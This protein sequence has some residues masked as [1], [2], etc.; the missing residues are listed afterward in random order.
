MGGEP[1]IHPFFLEMMRI[2]QEYF[3]RVTLFTNG[4]SSHLLE[5]DPREADGVNYNFN[6]GLAIKR[7]S[8][9]LDRLGARIIEVIIH[10]KTKVDVLIRNLDT[11]L[12]WSGK[13]IAVSL[14]LDCT[15]NIFAHRQQLVGTFMKVFDY[16]KTNELEVVLDHALPIC[17]VYGTGIPIST[18]GPLCNG[19]CAGMIDSD[20]SLHF[21]NQ[22]SEESLHIFSNN[23][24]VP[25]SLIENQLNLVHYKNQVNVLEK[26]CRDCPLYGRH[27]NGGCFVSNPVISREDIINNTQLPLV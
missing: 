16:C 1:T 15:E 6:F 12:S 27:C 25:F 22:L 9:M 23:R 2:A 10:H 24:L 18:R 5:F 20:L 4:L 13:R 17:F 3:E 8:Y 14:S 26:V 19:D 11:V 7:E 21:C